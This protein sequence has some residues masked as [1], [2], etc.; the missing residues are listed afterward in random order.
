MNAVF[1][2]LQ[3]CGMVVGLDLALDQLVE[4]AKENLGWVAPSLDNI[5]I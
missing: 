1:Q 4:S 3:Y 5:G 2:C